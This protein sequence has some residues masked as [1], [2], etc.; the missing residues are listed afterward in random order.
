MAIKKAFG[1]TFSKDPAENKRVFRSV[2]SLADFVTSAN[3]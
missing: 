1:V 2:G 3:A